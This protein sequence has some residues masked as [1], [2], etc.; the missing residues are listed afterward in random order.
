[1]KRTTVN[2]S[3]LGFVVLVGLSLGA[4]GTNNPQ[5]DACEAMAD[6]GRLAWGYYPGYG[7]GPVP[8]AQTHFSSLSVA[9]LPAEGA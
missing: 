3:A 4:C 1:M 8:P 9:A 6:G 7:C 5:N 2:R